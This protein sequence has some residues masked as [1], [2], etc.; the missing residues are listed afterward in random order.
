MDCSGKSVQNASPL[1]RS[2]AHPS[3]MHCE[4]GDGHREPAGTSTRSRGARGEAA[5]PRR[6]SSAW[7]SSLGRCLRLETPSARRVP[8]VPPRLPLTAATTDAT[9]SSPFWERIEAFKPH[10][11]E[12]SAAMAIDGMITAVA[13]A[14]AD[15]ALSLFRARGGGG[16]EVEIVAEAVAFARAAL[17]DERAE[18]W[19]EQIDAYLITGLR[20]RQWLGPPEVIR[21]YGA[22]S[23]PN[24]DLESLLGTL[25]KDAGL[26]LDLRNCSGRSPSATPSRCVRRRSSACCLG[27]VRACSSSSRRCGRRPSPRLSDHGRSA[28]IP[29]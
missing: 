3:S 20:V 21:I 14:S 22:I 11:R 9:T 4:L 2:P 19:L 1:G 16:A 26:I 15:S 24:P 17:T 5:D 23:A 6:V 29:E 8:I 25:A 13:Y 7:Q 18:W 12:D 28:W 10:D 27:P